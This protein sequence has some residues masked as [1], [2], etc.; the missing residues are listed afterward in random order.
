VAAVAFITGGA[1]GIGAAIG[2]ALAQRGVDVVLAD[3]QLELAEQVAEGIRQSG[4]WASAVEL[5]VRDPAQFENVVDETVARGGRIDYLFNNAGIGVAGDIAGYTLPDW[6]DVFDVNGTARSS[7]RSIG[8]A[9]LLGFRIWRSRPQARCPTSLVCLVS[10][11]RAST[12]DTSLDN[13]R[14]ADTWGTITETAH[15]C[16]IAH[17]TSWSLGARGEDRRSLCRVRR[18]VRTR[19]F[20]KAI[21]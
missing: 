7:V 21:R 8:T 16:S 19:A 1:S 20:G 10:T 12:T 3:R 15:T 9:S 11:C 6:Y 18:C 14:S 4:A 2:K 5:D 13:L 17:R